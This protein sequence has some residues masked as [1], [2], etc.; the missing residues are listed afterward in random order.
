VAT[1]T[2]SV[3]PV[4]DPPFAGNDSYTTNEDTPLA[5]ASPGVLANDTDIDGNPLSAILVAAPT[6]GSV[7]LNVNGSFLYTPASDYNGPDS[8]T[9]RAND[10]AA[11]SNLATV[12]I[13]VV[14]VNDAPITNNDTAVT[15][16]DTAV[17]IAVLANDLA[18]PAD[19]SG[20]TLTVT[21]LN[22]TAVTEGQVLATTHG[23]VRLNPN[24]TEAYTPAANY[25]GPDSFTYQATDD[26]TPP[27][28]DTATGTVAINPVN[29]APV[30][31]VDA[32]TTAEDGTLTVAASS[33]VLA[34]DTDVD[35]DTLGVAAP[36]PLIGPAHGNLTLNLDGSFTYTP[37]ANFNGTDTF[38]Y[39]ASDGIADSNVAIVTITITAVNDPPVA[40]P[41]AATTNEDTAVVIPIL[42]N[43]A[44]V[45]EVVDPATV[46]ITTAPAHGSV[47]PH[48]NGS[49]TYTPAG[50][51]N[52]PDSFKYTVNDNTGTVSN[53]TTV[54]ITVNPV[55]DAPV[56]HSDAYSLDEDTPLVVAAP[57]VLANDTDVDGDDL[58]ATVV[59]APAHGA[60]IFSSD[61]SFTYTPDTNYNGPDSFTYNVNDGNLDSDVVT[62]ML[63]VRPVNDPPVLD[64]DLDEGVIVDEGG[65]A[66]AA[67]AVSD[68]DAGDTVT[69]AASLGT[70][71][72][73]GDGTWGWSFGT[74]DGPLDS[75][76]VTITADDGH[77]GFAST[78][79]DLVVNNVPPT[80]AS[81]PGAT[82]AEGSHYTAPGTFSDP[83]TLDTWSATVDYG[84]GS[85]VQPLTLAGNSFAL[86]HLYARDG[87]YTVTVAVTDDDGGTDSRTASVVVQNVAPVVTGASVDRTTVAEN[88][89]VT[90][91]ITFTDPGTLDTHTAVVDWGDGSA[92]DT[93]AVNSMARSVLAQH[94]YLHNRPS[95]AA[96]TATVTVSDDDGGSAVA[97]T[98]VVVRNVAP[99]GLQLTRTATRVDENGTVGLSGTF[100]DPGTKDA[101]T[102]T[103]TWGDGAISTVPLAAGVLTFSA[104]HQYL[105]DGPSSGN[106]TPFD[107]NTVGVTVA[108]D[109]RG[110]TSADT[111]VTVDNVAPTVTAISDL[112]VVDEGGTVHFSGSFTDPGVL[113]AHTLSWQVTDSLNAIVA[114][115]TGSS[116]IFTPDDN[117]TYTATYTVTDDDGGT[118]S[119]SVVLAV[120]NVAPTP[121]FTAPSTG[122]EGSAISL[123]GSAI[124][125]STVDTTAGLALA[126][127][128]TKNDN[129]FAAGIGASFSFT[130]DD[131]GTYVVTLTATDKDGAVSGVASKTV[132]VTNVKPT[133]GPISVPAAPTIS[134]FSFQ[135]SAGFSDPGVLDTHT[136]VWN[137]GDGQTSSGLVTE[138]SGSGSVSGSHTYAGSGVYTITLTVTDKDGGS[139]QSTLQRTVAPYILLLDRTASGALSLSGNAGLNV[140]GNIVIDSNS[141]TAVVASGNAEV[142]SAGLKIVGKYKVSGNASLGGNVTTG[143]AVVADPLASLAAPTAGTLRGS[144]NLSSNRSQTIDPGVYTQIKVSGNAILTMRPGVYIIT[145]GGLSV[146]G[147]AA[148]AGSGV[149]IYNAGSNF[150]A[151]GIS[152]SGNGAINLTAPTT[153]TY[154][155]VLIFQ[156]RDN[157]RALALSGNADMEMRG[158]VYAPSA[159]LTIS[160][161]G[162]LSL[163]MIVDS[164]TL[165]GN[166]ASTMSADGA[167][168][169]GESVT[170][171]QLLS[172]DLY[173]YVNDAAGRFTA[174]ER[175]RID[176][177]VA[178]LNVLLSPFSV[179]V[180][181]VGTADIGEANVVL[182]TVATTPCGGLAEGVLGC[183]TDTGSVSEITLVRGWDWYAGADQS[184]A[185]AGQYDFETVVLHEL[186]HALG[187]GHSSEPVS[188]MYA[189]L[190]PGTSK[191]SISVADLSIPGDHDQGPEGLHAASL[192][193]RSGVVSAFGA[194]ASPIAFLAPPADAPVTPPAPTAAR[195]RGA[196]TL[197][198]TLRERAVT[199]ARTT[200]PALDSRAVDTLFDDGDGDGSVA[201][202]SSDVKALK[203]RRRPTPALSGWLGDPA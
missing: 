12:S 82:V 9:Y 16:E 175:V 171:G 150:P 97:T 93:V 94:R 200:A 167:S 184:A 62:V 203:A 57:G 64:A 113:D 92:P 183:E 143:A 44:D 133:A 194:S 35:G 71:I 43:D 11:N 123:I 76:I 129:A 201:L 104:T 147:N 198:D 156:A 103:I 137:W 99:S 84:D 182:D 26:G 20:Q 134:S 173:V 178:G 163:P 19:E 114:S 37:F 91:T 116:L 165:S 189:V 51:Y 5:I 172:R 49:V 161:N 185:G 72:D 58:M 60:L 139:G 98:G 169:A 75:Q 122:S 166:A 136:A 42:A 48:A 110:A 186:G 202:T 85:G 199:V 111:T 130:P 70:I 170:S 38:T 53:E 10:G 140:P 152:L 124:D 32:Y 155:G 29:D 162:G 146:S 54:N 149:T 95:D 109:D 68:A 3:S 151:P 105:D 176:D 191:R 55:N 108:D 154:A 83:G 188:T 40:N 193:G 168:A 131:N 28:S 89:V 121:S 100:L 187:L 177:A 145:G 197:Y 66:F 78:S 65:T 30:A 34:N 23:T 74:S 7:T 144:I 115:G 142:E 25:N 157:T 195:K 39:K 69:L 45:D 46:V 119:Q 96:Y 158:I 160:G 22:G 63:I 79:F 181:L 192:G 179:A 112:P 31:A 18:G 148:V 56:A 86:D 164:L 125:P 81:F 4:N 90:L 120:T 138:L 27:L 21:K 87:T 24:R 88:G 159:M 190:T 107:V 50:D 153:G 1:V 67:G 8:F 127:G 36:R 52:G 132:S 14:P 174:E 41:D 80:V 102:V 59:A 6:H 73:H 135:V 17:N 117:G 15:D 101:H 77:G 13:T 33:G 141:T 47:T 106:G 118:G 126:W 196:S 61:G 180:T 2:I 128:V